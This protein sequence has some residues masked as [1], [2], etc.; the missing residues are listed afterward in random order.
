MAG[1]SVSRRHD[2]VK[3]CG[4]Y[5]HVRVHDALGGMRNT[6]FGYILL[7]YSVCELK[8]ER[9]TGNLIASDSEIT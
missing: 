3:V 1:F 2:Y 7:G 6:G 5:C 8:Q 9:E 4:L